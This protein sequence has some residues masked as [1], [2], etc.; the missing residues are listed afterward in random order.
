MRDDQPE[1]TP[2][3]LTVGS[4]IVRM[5]TVTF[6]QVRPRLGCSLPSLGKPLV[7]VWTR[8]PGTGERLNGRAGQTATA[9]RVAVGPEFNS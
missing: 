7:S 1:A 6:H 8:E 4:E 2:V 3:R 9:K 5:N